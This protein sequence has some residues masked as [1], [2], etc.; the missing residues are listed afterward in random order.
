MTSLVIDTDIGDDVDDA[1]ALALATRLPQLALRGVVTVAGPVQRRA[2]LA[3]ALLAAA[4]AGD[5]PVFAGSSAM[6]DGRP[7]SGRF[8]HDGMQNAERRMQNA[9]PNAPNT[10][11][12]DFLNAQC[13]MLNSS[14]QR[15]IIAL[16]PLTNVAAA[17]DCDPALAGRAQVV[18]MAGK[19]GVPYPDWNLRCDPQAARRVLASGVPVRL[20]GMHLTLRTQ[21]RPEQL[22]RLFERDDALARFL[23]RCVLSWR[24]WKRRM[25]FLHDAL[26]VAAAVDPSLVAW[27][28]RRVLVEPRGFSLALRRGPPNALV[29][30]GVDIARF[31]G[32]VENALL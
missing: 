15:T 27:Q 17:L 12:T 31:W 25:P 19:L 28:P 26:T 9:E 32:M 13:S 11:V 22:R 23:G 20:V 18:A 10:A 7:G 5:V 30:V 21:M 24:T 1:F 14:A 3:R 29:G 8:T 4:G 16:G 2:A 6:R